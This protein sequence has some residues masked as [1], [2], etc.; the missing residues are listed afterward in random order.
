MGLQE[1]S[2][3]ELKEIR[4]TISRFCS[5]ASR[6]GK[7][8][9]ECWIAF[10]CTTQNGRTKTICAGVIRTT[11]CQRSQEK[12]SESS[13]RSKRWKTEGLRKTASTD[14]LSFATVMSLRGSGNTSA[15]KLI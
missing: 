5:T 14:E 15:A 3:E 7:A 9:I 8:A 13:E 10:F 11:H 12:T 1:R 6:S 4:K 2:Q